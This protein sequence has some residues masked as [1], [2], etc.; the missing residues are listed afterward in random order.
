VAAV[1]ARLQTEETEPLVKATREAVLHS[2]L[3]AAVVAPAQQEAMLRPALLA[4]LVVQDQ[5]GRRTV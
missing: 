3:V 5:H 4:V 2:V 1:V